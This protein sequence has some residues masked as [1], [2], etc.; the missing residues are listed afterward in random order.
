M[1]LLAIIREV[2][3]TN[4]I[5]IDTSALLYR[6]P[7]KQGVSPRRNGY[8]TKVDRQRTGK[9]WYVISASSWSCFTS[10]L[11]TSHVFQI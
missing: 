1:S 10:P 9:D 3:D 5:A 2:E 8:R 7:G 4:C 11:R 6:L